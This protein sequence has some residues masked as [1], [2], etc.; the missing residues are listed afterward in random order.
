ML[1]TFYGTCP[2]FPGSVFWNCNGQGL[3]KYALKIAK[4]AVICDEKSSKNGLKI[5]ISKYFFKKGTIFEKYI[6]KQQQH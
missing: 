1:K 5:K 2:S 3:L 6:K 4:Y